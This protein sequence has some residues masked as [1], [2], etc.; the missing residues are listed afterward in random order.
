M[1]ITFAVDF[2][3]QKA[4]GMM[5]MFTLKT[6]S[7]PEY[8]VVTESGVMSVD[9]HPTSS[10]LVVLGLYDGNVAVYDMQI[11][12]TVPQYCSNAISNK[13]ASTVWQVCYFPKF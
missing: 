12:C 5:C 7:N 9:I 6:P 13:H 3:E 11:S 1:N 4:D 10:H 2:R 8:S